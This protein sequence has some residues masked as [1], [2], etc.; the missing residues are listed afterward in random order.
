MNTYWIKVFVAAVFEVF[1]VIGL[2]HAESDFWTW[3][4][5]SYLLLS[6]AFI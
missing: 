2:K 4:W 1:W 5:N 6:L 3:S